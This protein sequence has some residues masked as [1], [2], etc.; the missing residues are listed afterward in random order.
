[1]R[2]QG[3]VLD[4]LGADFGQVQR[5]VEE[6]VRQLSAA[7]QTSSVRRRVAWDILTAMHGPCRAAQHL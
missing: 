2:A 4:V 1:M 7:A 3:D 6:A 5:L